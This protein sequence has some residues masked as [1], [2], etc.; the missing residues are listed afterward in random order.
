MAQIDTQK[1]FLELKSNISYESFRFLLSGKLSASLILKYLIKK[2][3][4]NPKLNEILVPKFMGWWVYSNIQQ[5]IQ[6]STQFSNYTK[7]IWLYHQ[8]GIPQNIKVKNF[9]DENKL[10]IIEDCAHVLKANLDD[11]KSD[12]LNTVY[13][14]FSFSKFIDCAPLGGIHSSDN[15][16]LLFLDN[17]INKSSKTQSI[18]IDILIRFSKLLDP[19]NLLHDKLF[20]VNYALWKFPS[21]N[22]ESKIKFFK[23]NIKEES[24]LR[25]N[26]FNLFKDEIKEKIYQDYFNYEDLICQKLPLVIENLNVQKNLIEKFEQYNFPYELLTYDR[27]RNFLNPK[28]DK[29]IIIDHSKNNSSFYKQIELIRK[30]A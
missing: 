16:F 20:S 8:F 30:L 6:V 5:S 13:S 24:D 1:L 25:S 19:N 10:L 3:N 29:T 15:N 4:I 17:E 23:K 27:N 11:G 26:N 9:A 12:I 21:K 2:H 7:I 18:L 14:L 28:F 22:L